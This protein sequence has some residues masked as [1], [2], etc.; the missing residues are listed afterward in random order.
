MA[1]NA[2]TRCELSSRCGN[3]KIE[4][5]T[6]APLPLS[7]TSL[8]TMSDSDDDWENSAADFKPVVAAKPAAALG[9]KGQAVLAS[10]AEPDLSKFADEDKEEAP[11][12]VEHTIKPQVCAEYQCLARCSTGLRARDEQASSPC[13]PNPHA[14][15]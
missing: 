8:N 2:R 1:L 7:V 6:T 10:A 15:A 9:T 11:A 3:S 12:P 13:S 5:A 14:C 4:L